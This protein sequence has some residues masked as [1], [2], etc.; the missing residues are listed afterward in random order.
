MAE[1]ID[2]ADL[3]P[4]PMPLNHSRCTSDSADGLFNIVAKLERLARQRR[5]PAEVDVR[6]IYQSSAKAED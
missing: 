1:Q 2:E 5:A 4:R 3:D 6:L